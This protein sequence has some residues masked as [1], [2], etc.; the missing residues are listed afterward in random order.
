MPATLAPFARPVHTPDAMRDRLV[1]QVTRWE[2]I[3]A[4]AEASQFRSGLAGARRSLDA[5]RRALADFDGE[6]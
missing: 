5:A 6:G 4:T 1:R 2:R 3:V